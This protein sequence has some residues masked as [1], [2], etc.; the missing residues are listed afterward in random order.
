MV[1]VSCGWAKLQSKSTL[2][3]LLINW[4][5]RL[6]SQL[7]CWIAAV[8]SLDET[9]CM[10]SGLKLHI[11]TGAC[12]FFSLQ[13][14]FLKQ[15]WYTELVV[16]AR[17]TLQLKHF[18]DCRKSNQTSALLAHYEHHRGDQLL[19]SCPTNNCLLLRPVIFL[20]ALWINVIKMR[21][22]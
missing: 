21:T 22:D 14:H 5:S 17:C 7:H 12:I 10:Y 6:I 2:V 11:P 9:K 8:L 15:K 19:K 18:N 13:K 4:K 20:K 16:L 3:M 1:S